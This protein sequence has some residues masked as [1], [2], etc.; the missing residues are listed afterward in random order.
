M[1]QLD[2]DAFP[3]PKLD[4]V[5]SPLVGD[6]FSFSYPYLNPGYFPHYRNFCRIS[7]HETPLSIT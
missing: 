5:S 4:L 6:V 1:A 2:G 7:A 3:F